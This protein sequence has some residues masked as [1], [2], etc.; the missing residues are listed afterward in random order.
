M[1]T[2][3]TEPLLARLR[4]I[5]DL[6]GAV[7]V[8]TWDQNVKM[9]PGGAEARGRQLATLER[10]RHERWLDPGLERDLAA[11]ERDVPDGATADLVRVVRHD[12]E[13]ALR[14]P[15]D[16][17]AREAAHAAASYDAWLD[18]RRTGAVERVVGMLERTLD[19]SL[20]YAGFFPECAHPADALIDAADEGATVASLRPLFGRLRDALVPRVAAWSAAPPAPPLPAGP[21]AVDEQLAAALELAQAFGYDV[22][23]GRQDLTAH[24]FAIRFAHGDV[25]ITTRAKPDD[26]T[27]VLFSTLH[28]AGHAMYEQGVD[29]R[30]E[31]TPLAEGASAGVHE[32]QARL[33]ENQ[34]A[35]SRA[36]W[37]FAL[38]RLQRRFPALTGVD[39]DTA[40]RAVN[41]VQRSL[42]R[43]DADEVTYNL[44]VIVRFDL[45]L[46]LL[47]GRLAVR[48]LAEAWAQRYAADLGVT[49]TGDADGWLQDVHWFA[50]P[51]GG[52]F[53]GY[54]LGNV[55]SAQ[56]FA[57]AARELG[58][59]GAQMAVG[60]FA[61]LRTWLTENVYRHGRSKPVDRLVRDATGGPLDVGPYLTYLDRKFEALVGAG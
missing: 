21:F 15:N 48:D 51:I 13:R 6:G 17:V 30:L 19:L 59:V 33:W 20:E 49:P 12:L 34:V 24:P 52:S 47:E 2:D 53:Q 37:S 28:E 32:S 4:E 18:A 56:F 1:T 45:E 46:E 7:S 43:T 11:V 31:G 40:F 57:A 39:V 3:V 8:L 36:F 23:R 38:P 42:I 60:D 29:P 10:L 9:P 44:H 27:E 54:T 14:V 41:R 25:R 26:L 16:Y 55:L 61:P 22:E 58:D 50:G 5:E 35:R